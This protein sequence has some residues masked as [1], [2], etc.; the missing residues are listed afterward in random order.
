MLTTLPRMKIWRDANTTLFTNIVYIFSNSLD[1]C[2][3]SILDSD[4]NSPM[5]STQSPVSPSSPIEEGIP[6]LTTKVSNLMPQAVSS[7]LQGLD[8]T[9][10]YE[11]GACLFCCS[12]YVWVCGNVCCVA[13]VVKDI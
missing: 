4:P 2:S 12:N 11:Y 6:S 13:A 1:S 9:G 5:S 3:G 10:V 8:T 7:A